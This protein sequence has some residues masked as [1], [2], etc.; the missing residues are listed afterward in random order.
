MGESSSKIK[1]KTSKREELSP[2]MQ[3]V[4]SKA[5]IGGGCFWCVEAVFQRLKGVKEVYSG[6]AGGDVKDPTYKQVCTGKTGHAE[7]VQI[8]Y[9]SKE[10]AYKDLLKVFFMTHDPTTLN[11]QGNDIGTQYRSVIF[12]HDDEQKVIA[13]N[14]IKEIDESK[15][16]QNKIVTEVAP[17]TIFYKAEED[18]QN[19]YNEN[20]TSNGYC[21]LVVKSKVD[22]FLKIFK[23]QS[24]PSI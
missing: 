17:L 6:Y 20:G 14:I 22:K 24:Q 19:Y 3:S 16:Y 18:H 1:N 15:Y 7:V 5:T 8:A 11:Q 23:D 12:Y 10:L 21:K 9:D 2:D 13:H 4:L